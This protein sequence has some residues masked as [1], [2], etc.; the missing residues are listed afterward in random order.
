MKSDISIRQIFTVASF[1]FRG[2][3]KNPRAIM[4]FVLA[5]VLCT[6]LTDKAISFA[7]DYGTNMQIMEAFIWTFG[8]ANSIMISSLLLILLF[9]DMPFFSGFTP[10]Y[11]VRTKRNIWLW[12]QVLYVALATLI[13]M[14]FILAVTM[15]IS[16]HISFIGNMWSETGAILAFSGFGAE[17]MLPT[18]L[19]A[20][21]LSYPY[22]CALHVFLLMVGYT[23]FLASVMLMLNI[24]LGRF[25][26]VMGAFLLSIYG[27]LLNPEI[28]MQIFRLPDAVAYRANVA[29][30][31]L[32]PLNHAT[33][34]MHNFGYDFLPRL[35]MSYAIFTVMTAIC[36]F[37]ARRGMEKYSFAFT[38]TDI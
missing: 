28:F 26:G 34:H 25:W 31:W 7:H 32:S 15:A 24:R 18:S 12:G 19:K 11:L 4:V 20:M 14:V 8:D 38:G 37:M 6:L 35:W 17:I 30:G 36:L 29:V 21:I 5:F 3:H 27:L 10:Y 23:L 2:W 13:Y 16:M 1:N 22:Q 33:F 9:A